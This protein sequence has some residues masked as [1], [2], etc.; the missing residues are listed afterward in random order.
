[1]T[2][3]KPAEK[4][5]VRERILEAALLLLRAS[6]TGKLAQPQVAREAGFPSWPQRKA[7]VQAPRF[8][9]RRRGPKKLP[10]FSRLEELYAYTLGLVARGDPAAL[11]IEMPPMPSLRDNLMR[12][13]TG[14]T[15]VLI[16][17]EARSAVTILS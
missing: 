1:M 15:S 12:K 6:V 9:R 4:R 2:D 16:P 13:L 14:P 3:D 17:F 8:V 5:G 7:F 11:A 10:S